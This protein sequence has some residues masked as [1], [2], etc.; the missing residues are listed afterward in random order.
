MSKIKKKQTKSAHQA[1]FRSGPAVHFSGH[2]MP[3]ANW[4]DW[5]A[6]GVIFYST[7]LT[8][9][10]VF[11]Y[12]NVHITKSPLPSLVLIGS[13]AVSSEEHDKPEWR[14]KACLPTEWH[15]DNL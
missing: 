11:L 6:P 13:L 12:T 1:I 3:L 2:L 14:L 10:I 9:P 5:A 15:W 8:T 4:H 7:D